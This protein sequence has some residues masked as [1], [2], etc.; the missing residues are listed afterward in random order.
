MLGF[1]VPVTA[2]KLFSPGLKCS[3]TVEVRALPVGKKQGLESKK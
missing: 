3:G 2:W 1:A